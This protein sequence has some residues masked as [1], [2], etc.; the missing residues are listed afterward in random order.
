MKLAPPLSIA[1]ASKHHDFN[2][3]SSQVNKVVPLVTLNQQAIG[4]HKIVFKLFALYSLFT[5]VQFILSL[6]HI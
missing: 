5:H 6:I 2:L 1:N 4:K 3:V